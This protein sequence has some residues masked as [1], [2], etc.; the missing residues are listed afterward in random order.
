MTNYIK[1]ISFF[2]SLSLAIPAL[3]MESMEIDQSEKRGKK[4]K[5]DAVYT[6]KQP[7]SLV[8]QTTEKFLQPYLTGLQRSVTKNRVVR[9]QQFWNDTSDLPTDV[10]RIV[11][12]SLQQ[13]WTPPSIYRPTESIKFKTF[14]LLL[15]HASADDRKTLLIEFFASPGALTAFSESIKPTHLEIISCPLFDASLQRMITQKLGTEASLSLSAILMYHPLKTIKKFLDLGLNVHA[16][17][18]ETTNLGEDTQFPLTTT[19]SHA[20]EQF[21]FDKIDLL[22]NYNA[23]IPMVCPTDNAIIHTIIRGVLGSEETR[24]KIIER[25]VDSLGKKLHTDSYNRHFIVNREEEIV[26]PEECIPVSRMLNNF[27]GL[28]GLFTGNYAVSLQ[29]SDIFCGLF[30]QKS[31]EPINNT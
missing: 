17:S 28:T 14:A 8:K 9:C 12:D 23:A 5:H 26:H 24:D 13:K 1:L 15:K 11:F 3:S 18:P 27:R 4:R 22:L 30:I 6:I 21:N 20:I 7:T 2:I 10:M 16:Y 29:A 31:Q 25:L 19:L